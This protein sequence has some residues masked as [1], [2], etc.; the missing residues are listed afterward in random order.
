M[1]HHFF[2]YPEK[3]GRTSRS[4]SGKRQGPWRRRPRSAPQPWYRWCGLVGLSP[5]PAEWVWVGQGR[6]SKAA[7]CLLMGMGKMGAT[8]E[9]WTI[10]EADWRLDDFILRIFT[11]YVG[12]SGNLGFSQPIHG[13]FN[14]AE[15]WAPFAG[16]N[17]L[18]FWFNSKS[19]F[20]FKSQ[21]KE[22]HI[23]AYLLEI[24]ML[25]ADII[26]HQHFLRS[27]CHCISRVTSFRQGAIL[28]SSGLS[29]DRSK[30][31]WHLTPQCLGEV[32]IN[33]ISVSYSVLAKSS[34]IRIESADFLMTSP[35]IHLVFPYVL[36]KSTIFRY[37]LPWNP[38]FKSSPTSQLGHDLLPP[39]QQAAG[40]ESALR[41]PLETAQQHRLCHGATTAGAR[42]QEGMG[43]IGMGCEKRYGLG[44]VWPNQ[45]NLVGGSATPLKNMKVNWDDEIPNKW[46]NKKCSKPP[47]SNPCF[48]AR[49]FC[50]RT[51]SQRIEWL[52]NSL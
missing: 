52:V 43:P 44:H 49:N 37:F 28:A 50:E 36:V 5:C 1:F 2:E 27:F 19:P 39:R 47:T 51:N 46:E 33:I 3:N 16:A 25:N 34:E 40:G 6:G 10:L 22:R 8:W 9:K 41:R 24:C 20:F 17:P 30:I 26:W 15:W 42:S 13:N 4:E 12:V 35:E 31:I 29:H 21:L 11:L 14:G 32:P 18:P 45:P 48:S 7:G 38:P 23:L